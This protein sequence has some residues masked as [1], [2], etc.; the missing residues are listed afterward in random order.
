MG[1]PGAVHQWVDQVDVV[2]PEVCEPASETGGDT[3]VLGVVGG[4]VVA[5]VFELLCVLDVPPLTDGE[6]LFCVLVLPPLTDGE[7]VKVGCTVIAGCTLIIA[8]AEALWL[9]PRP[10]RARVT[11]PW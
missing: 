8:A 9:P 5:A 7:M 11:R 3:V 1:V 4:V 2:F 6:M 10:C